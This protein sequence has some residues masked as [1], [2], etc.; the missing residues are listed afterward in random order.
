MSTYI[1]CVE[2]SSVSSFKEEKVDCLLLFDSTRHSNDLQPWL[3]IKD[4]YSVSYF[5]GESFSKID[6]Y[7]TIIDRFNGNL[8]EYIP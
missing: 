6:L 3:L 1:W 5:N 4:L 7:D 8:E 2:I